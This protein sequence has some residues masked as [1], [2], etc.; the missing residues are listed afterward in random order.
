[1]TAFR[2]FERK[3]LRLLIARRLGPAVTDALLREA[4]LIAIDREDTLYSLVATHDSLL[5]GTSEFQFDRPEVI[6]R[7]EDTAVRFKAAISSNQLSLLAQSTQMT[8]IPEYF[9]ERDIEIEIINDA[10]E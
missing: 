7:Y 2:D 6:G 8:E 5:P 4:T 9:R 3:A 10:G 1:M